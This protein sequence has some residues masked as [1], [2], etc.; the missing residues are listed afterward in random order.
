MGLGR[1]EGV[2]LGHCLGLSWADLQRTMAYH[3]L[4]VQI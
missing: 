4:R 1:G 3:D 2:E